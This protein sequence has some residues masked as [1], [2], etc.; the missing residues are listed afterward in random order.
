MLIYLI[1]WHVACAPVT[2][3]WD[4]VLLES[5]IHPD[6]T[7]RTFPDVTSAENARAERKKKRTGSQK[8]LTRGRK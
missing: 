3:S 8:D 2:P 5:Q 4:R 7:V 1:C 6:A